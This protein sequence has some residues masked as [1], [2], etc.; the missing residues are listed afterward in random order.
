MAV[1]RIGL[2]G[3][4]PAA[5]GATGQ[6]TIWA[7]SQF[8]P[9]TTAHTITT[10]WASYSLTDG[11]STTAE[12]TYSAFYASGYE[13][14]RVHKA[15]LRVTGVAGAGADTTNFWVYPA[16]SANFASFSGMT[17]TVSSG[18]PGFKAMM[19]TGGMEPR[20]L[21]SSIRPN[22]VLG[23]TP[24]E[25]NTAPGSFAQPNASNPGSGFGVVF[26]VTY[27]TV[28]GGVTSGQVYFDFQLEMEIEY[29]SPLV[30]TS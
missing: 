15:T 6:A 5:S 21:V 13:A 22:E 27:A 26:A 25:Y 16:A 2:Q 12:P 30:L 14:Y 28:D 8:Q 11:S 17:Y 24:I 10:G 9:F 3:Y 1:Q 4:L 29:F 20:T 7:N 23:M 18:I 19:I